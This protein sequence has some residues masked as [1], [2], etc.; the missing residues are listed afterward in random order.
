MDCG[1][2]FCH[3]AVDERDGVGLPL[4]NLIPGVERPRLPRPW[5]EALSRLH[6]TNNFPEFT[7]ASAHQ[8]RARARACSASATRTVA[9]KSR[10]VRHHR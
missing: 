4:G 10:R 3:R 5:R 7:A 9:I 2:P 6:Q 8:R 1:V